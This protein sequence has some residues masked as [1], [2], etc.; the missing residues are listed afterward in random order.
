M[1]QQVIRPEVPKSYRIAVTAR[2]IGECGDKDVLEIGAGDFSF[3]DMARNGQGIGL[4]HQLDFSPPCD[5]LVDLNVPH[6]QIPR[7]ENAYDL[8][9]CTEVL[10]HLLWPHRVLQEIGRVLRPEGRVIVGIPNICS[11]SYR[12]A[13]LMGRVPSCAASGNLPSTLG[14]SA[15]E[16]IDGGTVGGHVVDFN[17]QKLKAMFIYCGFAIQEI[18]GTGLFWKRD[19]IHPSL[20]PPSLASNVVIAA[21]RAI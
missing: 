3:R 19:R 11:I 21:T 20:L 16:T 17:V 10:E 8:V 15:Y 12:V 4:W 7:E 6:P 9:I 2:M 13:W 14:S 1:S 18:Q 5:F